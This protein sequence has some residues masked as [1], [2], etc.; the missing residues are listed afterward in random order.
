MAGTYLPASQAADAAEVADG[1]ILARRYDRSRRSPDLSRKRP[2]NESGRGRGCQLFAS[3]ASAV[4]A[5]APVG[6]WT[7]TER[8]G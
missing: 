4:P 3:P 2:L 6:V 7:P 5:G 1:D 8:R